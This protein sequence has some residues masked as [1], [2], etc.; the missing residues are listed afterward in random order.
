[1][2]TEV[3]MWDS[4]LWESA[5]CTQNI[6][7][8]NACVVFCTLFFLKEKPSSAF[9]SNILEI[10]YNLIRKGHFNILFRKEKIQMHDLIQKGVL[11]CWPDELQPGQ[12]LSTPRLMRVKHQRKPSLRTSTALTGECSPEQRFT[13]VLAKFHT[14]VLEKVHSLGA[15]LQPSH[16]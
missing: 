10:S 2:P 14:Q 6:G 8:V 15:M 16:V 4:M 7:I 12:C 3:S 5:S 9:F 13:E 11:P 1:M